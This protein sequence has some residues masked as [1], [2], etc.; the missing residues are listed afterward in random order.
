MGDNT[1]DGTKLCALSGAPRNWAGG[2]DWGGGG[3]K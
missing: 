3:G 1:G 2:K